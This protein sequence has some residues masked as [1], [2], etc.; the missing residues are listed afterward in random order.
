VQGVTKA[1]LEYAEKETVQWV[2]EAIAATAEEYRIWKVNP[3]GASIA[4]P[5]TRSQLD[6]IENMLVKL[7]DA[8]GIPLADLE[9]AASHGT[10]MEQAGAVI[11]ITSDAVK[12]AEGAD[13]MAAGQVMVP[14]IKA[15]GGMGMRPAGGLSPAAM[16]AEQEPK[17]DWKELYSYASHDL[18]EEAELGEQDG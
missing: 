18:P 17:P 14:Y 6:R 3:E 2:P 1:I 5:A 15:G 12:L 13:R 11:A 16:R 9:L 10:L 8:L 7:I 4:A